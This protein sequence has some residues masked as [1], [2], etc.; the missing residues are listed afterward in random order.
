MT[1][2]ADMKRGSR[3]FLFREE[4]REVRAQG[5]KCPGGPWNIGYPGHDNMPSF[6]F[7]PHSSVPFSE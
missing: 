5:E 3:R 1:V 6:E 2:P 4:L 7:T